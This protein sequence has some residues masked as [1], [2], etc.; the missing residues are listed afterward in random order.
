LNE[1]QLDKVEK[2]IVERF[3]KR[4]RERKASSNKQNTSTITNQIY[5]KRAPTS[6]KQKKRNKIKIQPKKN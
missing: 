4:E 1:E 2:N 6:Q 5:N 3:K